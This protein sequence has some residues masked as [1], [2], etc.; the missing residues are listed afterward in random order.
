MLYDF[1]AKFCFEYDQP[2]IL[3]LNTYTHVNSE[4]ADVVRK[5][6]GS[7]RYLNPFRAKALSECCGILVLIKCYF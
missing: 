5:V 3:D 4:D 1:C 2:S 7:F 6:F